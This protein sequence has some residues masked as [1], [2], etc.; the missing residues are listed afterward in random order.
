MAGERFVVPRDGQTLVGERWPGPGP[1]VVLLHAGVTDRRGW[2]AVAERLQPDVD[3][4]AYDRRGFGETPPGDGHFTH[5]EDLLAVL[6]H[7]AVAGRP[8]WLVGSSRG[9][10][11]AVD[12]ALVAPDRVAGLVLIAAGVR[13][14]PSREEL[15]AEF[16]WLDDAL[17]G[18][19]E[20]GDLGEINRLETLVW[21]DGPAGPEGRVGG[22]A[23]ALAVAMNA[24]VLA[25]RSDEDAGASG[26]DTWSR[27]SE[28]HLPATVIWGDRDLPSIVEDSRMLADRLPHARTRV[29]AGT[30]HLP[31]L[32]SPA[33]VAD[34]LLDALAAAPG[35]LTDS[36][37]VH[38]VD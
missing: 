4:V 25:H 31:Y 6:D 30:A 10:G 3:V 32:E 27:L 12:A 14:T 36:G 38:D 2:R 8:V 7:P 34:A 33:V 16:A 35:P 15:D 21:L 22:E 9:G 5:L 13:G 23:R 26:I 1:T 24:V 11:L 29:L 37:L 19:Y 20:A 28:L 17:L 18:A